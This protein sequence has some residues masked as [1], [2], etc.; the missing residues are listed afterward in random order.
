MRDPRS[1]KMRPSL[2]RKDDDIADAE[3]VARP[4][5]SR[6]TQEATIQYLEA[7][8]VAAISIVADADGIA[9]SVDIQ[10]DAVAAFWLPADMVRA[11]A[12]KARNI[13]GSDPDVEGA[14]AAPQEAAVQLRVRLTAHDTAMSRAANAAERLD[15]YVETL[16][17]SGVMKQFTKTY[18]ARRLAAK[19]RGEGFMTFS[20]AELRFKRALIPLLQNGGKPAVGSSLFREV[21]D[22]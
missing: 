16:R 3:P 10:R 13:A 7:I 19:E 8:N 22:T 12:T 11:V 9:I 14:V 5:T 18:K 2:S 1:G 21:F 15:A 4:A 6:Q 20:A 17:A